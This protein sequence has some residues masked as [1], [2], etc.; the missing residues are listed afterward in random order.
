MFRRTCRD[1]NR[2]L[3]ATADPKG[4]L[5]DLMTRREPYYRE[6]ADLV[7][8]TGSTPIQTLVKGL[9]PQLQAFEKRI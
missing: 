6:V 9:L 2:P 5:R 8:E 4:T 7:V 3:L 1:R